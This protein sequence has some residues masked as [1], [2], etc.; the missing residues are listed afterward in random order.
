M[1]QDRAEVGKAR[2]K[3]SIRKVLKEY[4]WEW[5]SPELGSAM[6][7]EKIT[8]TLMICEIWAMKTKMVTSPREVI[9][10]LI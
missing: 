3:R 6:V 1:I 7:T 5:L 9:Y 8:A 4:K 10:S 2:G